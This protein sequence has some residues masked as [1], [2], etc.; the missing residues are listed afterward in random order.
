MKI[1][2]GKCLTSVL[3]VRTMPLWWASLALKK[4]NTHDDWTAGGC[5]ADAQPVISSIT[6]QAALR[7]TSRRL[8]LLLMAKPSNPIHLYS[9][10]TL[11]P[12]CL[13]IRELCCV[14]CVG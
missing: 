10:E 8:F 1:I 2:S 13:R 3:F 7:L 6:N 11:S 4:R 12:W 5:L 14:Q 9:L